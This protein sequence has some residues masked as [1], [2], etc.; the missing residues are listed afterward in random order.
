MLT[1]YQRMMNMG[2]YI[3]MLTCSQRMMNMGI[4]YNCCGCLFSSSFDFFPPHLI[5]IR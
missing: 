2:A 1:C 5:T 4:Q 3:Y